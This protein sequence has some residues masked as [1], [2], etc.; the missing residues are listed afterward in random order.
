MTA[1]LVGEDRRPLAGSGARGHTRGTASRRSSFTVGLCAP[2]L[3][4]GA[5]AAQE[6]E[7]GRFRGP[8]GSG[9]SA[10]RHL[11]ATLDPNS[12]LA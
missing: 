12:C 8:D 4:A 5:G 7:W 11:P 1:R 6:P 10:A 2:C 9:V 3:A